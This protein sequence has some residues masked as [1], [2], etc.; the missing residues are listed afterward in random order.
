GLALGAG[1]LALGMGS[2]AAAGPEAGHFGWARRAR[3]AV[4]QH[5]LAF[6]LDSVGAS[7]AQESK[8]H[9]IVAANFAD[10][11]PDPK[12]REAFRKQVLDLLGAPT[13][14]RAAVEK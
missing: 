9:D 6:L 5:G 3:R 12:E 10:L 4:I 7:T 11:A 1:S 8:A 13:I 2:L 14:D